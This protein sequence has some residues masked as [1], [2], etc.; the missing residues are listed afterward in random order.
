MRWVRV[1]GGKFGGRVMHG[2]DW[3]CRAGR[4]E[5]KGTRK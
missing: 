5:E 3:G 2:R 1:G 4:K